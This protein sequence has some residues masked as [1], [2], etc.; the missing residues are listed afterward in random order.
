[1]RERA[2]EGSE[3]RKREHSYLIDLDQERLDDVAADEFEIGMAPV[4][5]SSRKDYACQ[6]HMTPDEAAGLDA[7][8]RSSR[9]TPSAKG[10]SCCR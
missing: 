10:C 3:G 9:L 8:L 7:T 1:M 2:V 4:S 5:L 6:R